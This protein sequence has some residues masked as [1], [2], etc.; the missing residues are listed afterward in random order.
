MTQPEIHGR[1]DIDPTHPGVRI[2]HM[3]HGGREFVVLIPEPN[4]EMREAPVSRQELLDRG[5]IEVGALIVDD[6]PTSGSGDQQ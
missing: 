3:S 5:W 4:G 2:K 1:M 6:E